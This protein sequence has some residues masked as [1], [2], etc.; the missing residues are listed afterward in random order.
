MA[1]SE[2]QIKVSTFLEAQLRALQSRQICL[3]PPFIIGGLSIQLQQIAFGNNSIRHN[4]PETFP[5]FYSEP[6]RNPDKPYLWPTPYDAKGF[7]TQIAQELSLHFTLTSDILEHPNQPPG[8]VTTVPVAVVTRLSYYPA[9]LGGCVIASSFDHLEW[10]PLPPLPP[11]V[12]PSSFMQFIED[13]LRKSLASPVIPFNFAPLLPPGMTEI[14]NAGVSVDSNLQ[15]I[16][17]RVDPAG[18]TSSNDLRWTDFHSGFI[19]DRVQD[20]DWGLFIEGKVLESSLTAALERALKRNPQSGFRLSSVGSQYSDA[21]G[22][23]R[24]VTTL[25]AFIEAPALPSFYVNPSI[26]S[27]LSLEPSTNDLVFDVHLDEIQALIE[28]ITDFT[29]TLSWFVPLLGFVQDLLFGEELEKLGG[30]LGGISPPQVAGFQCTKLSD[31]H[32]RCTFSASIPSVSGAAM[33]LTGLAALEDG[34]SLIGRMPARRFTPSALQTSTGEFAWVPPRI[35]CGQSSNS[36][37]EDIR[38]N[39]TQIASLRAE[40]SLEQTGTAPIYVCDVKVVNDPLNVFPT[41]APGLLLERTLLPT[42]III[43]MRNPSPEYSAAAYDLELIV[44]TTAGVRLIKIPPPL[45]MTPETI[46]FLV[47]R[48]R[49]QLLGC[50]AIPEWFGG[51]GRFDLSWITDPL[52]D[53]PLEMTAGHFWGIEIRGLREGQTAAL[54]DLASGSIVSKVAQPDLPLRLTALVLPTEDRELTVMR[55]VPQEELLSFRV[56]GPMGEAPDSRA[57][58]PSGLEFTGSQHGRTQEGQSSVQ[59]KEHGIEIQQQALWQVRSIRLPSLCR[60]VLSSSLLANSGLVAVLQDEIVSLDLSNPYLPK[61]VGVWTQQGLS[62]AC[63]WDRGLLVFGR[64]GFVSIASDSILTSVGPN[65]EPYPVVD[66]VVGSSVAYVLTDATLEVRSP[67]LCLM[68]GF[69]FDGG[70]CVA[71]L[72]RRLIVGG[73]AGIT[74]YDVSDE[75]R[76][77]LETSQGELDVTSIVIPPDG[78]ADSILAIL[79]DGSARMF[80]I[81]DGRLRESAIYSGTPWFAKSLRIGNLFVQVGSGRL[82]LKISTIG[83]PRLAVPEH[84]Q[85]SSQS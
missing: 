6:R 24:I 70:S 43:L 8:T 34:I 69:P 25:H 55:D 2:V 65:C 23:A 78:P 37:L 9:P 4:V 35:T 17:F 77:C 67:R 15:R 12:D 30:V 42:K 14:A 10:G 5:V 81:S 50:P 52:L 61:R 59:Q 53:P 32:H 21:F 71:Q 40:V 39:P 66:V 1:L 60:K 28:S 54:V 48:V 73:R 79:A 45:P 22:I 49:V 85:F 20:V 58:R 41:V 57:P 47:S 7:K 76:P 33:R 18:G 19:A 13:I 29:D 63:V 83:E 26:I 44:A 74:V 38:Q 27:V 82:H 36:T 56:G 68:S 31:V 51:L 3:P 16:V 84:N 62:G 46:K 80:T 11:G 64:D 72:G 75:R